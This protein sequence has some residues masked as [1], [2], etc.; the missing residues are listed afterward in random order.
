MGRRAQ[1]SRTV[2]SV[3]LTERV[4]SL[5]ITPRTYRMVTLLALLAL[6]FI[7]VTGA[8]VRLTGSG[9]GCSD[10][11]NCEPGSL[12][13]PLEY[14]AM[15]EFVNRLVTGLV[16]IA[17]IAAVLG[18]LLRVP[19]RR[20]LVYLSFGLVA[21]VI[22]QIVLGGLTVIF[23][24]RPPFVMGH[25]LLSMVLVWNAVVLHYRAGKPDGPPRRAV[26]TRL[27]RTVRTVY[28]VAALVVFTGTVVTA[29]GPHGGDEDAQRFS[30]DLPDV[31]RIHAGSVI[32]LA[33]LVL[34]VAWL[35]SREIGRERLIPATRT[36][37][38]LLLAQA[39][40]GYVQYFNELPPVLV[41]I[42]VAGA[43]AIWST[44]VFLHERCFTRE[45]AR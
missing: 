27:L 25:F 38:L 28:A 3:S 45:P 17:V 12:V 18:S 41:G 30:F 13:A 29:S 7:I 34:F 42:H 10:W 1:R 33:V 11:P 8:S 14:H 15:I 4:R 37:L 20:D 43:V 16:S 39:T 32:L 2:S 44:V 9:L 19:R 6:A 24:L 22:A 5:S 21:G 35:E 40:V 36:L 31:T 26:S 23:E